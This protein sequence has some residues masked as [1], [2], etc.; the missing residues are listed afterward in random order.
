MK[1]RFHGL[2]EEEIKARGPEILQKAA[3][4]MD[5]VLVE[6]EPDFIEKSFLSST[7]PLVTELEDWYYNKGKN[8]LAKVKNDVL[9]ELGG[10][11]LMDY[12][13]IGRKQFRDKAKANTT[14]LAKS[15]LALGHIRNM[16][17]NPGLS[18]R[19]RRQLFE[20]AQQILSITDPE[21]R[22]RLIDIYSQ[23]VNLS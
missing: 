13:I 12:G 11:E 15:R 8:I 10:E 6:K 22:G 19:T 4:A 3:K 5:V 20:R 23:I 18:K 17:T 1:F 21:K 9:K 14:N 2:T 16:L 7:V